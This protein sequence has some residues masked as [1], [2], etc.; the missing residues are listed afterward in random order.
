M[1]TNKVTVMMFKTNRIPLYVDTKG[2][3]GVAVVIG[4]SVGGGVLLMLL[5][6][7]VVGTITC[8]ACA[9]NKK[10]GWSLYA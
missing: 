5:I 4:A 10:K 1:A 8:V 6:I 3:V 2:E 9:K 7:I